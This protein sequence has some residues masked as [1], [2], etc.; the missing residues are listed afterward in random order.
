MEKIA[1]P[2]FQN[3]SLVLLP[4]DVLKEILSYRVKEGDV[5]PWS[6]CKK[7]RQVMEELIGVLWRNLKANNNL[8]KKCQME[9]LSDMMSHLET[10]FGMNPPYLR[11][12]KLLA[13]EIQVSFGIH[14]SS[15]S[16]PILPSHFCLKRL[17]DKSLR[18]VSAVVDPSPRFVF[19]K[20]RKSK[21]RRYLRNPDNIRALQE[22]TNLSIIGNVGMKVVPPDLTLLTQLQRLDL[23]DNNLIYLPDLSPLI[24]LS[25]LSLESNQL[26]SIN[27]L[28]NLSELRILK[29]RKNNLTALPDISNLFQLE[30]LDLSENKL[31]TMP[32]SL[33]KLTCLEDLNLKDNQLSELPQMEGKTLKSM[34][35]GGNK[36]REFPNFPELK[37]LCILNNPLS[38]LTWKKV[39][40]FVRYM[41]LSGCQL[42]TLPEPIFFPLIHTWDLSENQLTT[43]PD[44][45]KLF[46]LT[47]LDL[48]K[49]QFSNLPNLS[50]PSHL[51]VLKISHNCITDLSGLSP[52]SFFLKVLEV[53]F[54]PIQK[55]PD[56]STFE[57][58]HTFSASG[59]QIKFLPYSLPKNIGSLTLS[60]SGLTDFSLV[61]FPNLYMLTLSHNKLSSVP[62]LEALERLWYLDLGHNQLTQIPEIKPLRDLRSL[63]LNDNQLSEIPEFLTVDLW[64]LHL[65]NNNLTSLDS[66]VGE[67]LTPDMILH[68]N[69]WKFPLGHSIVENFIPFL[70]RKLVEFYRFLI[71]SNSSAKSVEDQ[72]KQTFHNLPNK[73]KTRF[74]RVTGVSEDEI[75]THMPSF[76]ISFQRFMI[77]PFFDSRSSQ[78]TE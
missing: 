32:Q 17:F 14:P 72:I 56:L 38:I 9:L 40:P 66:F 1:Q 30:S 62:G 44:T 60:H 6:V 71:S 57:L 35:L 4:N 5:I 49:N 74:Y 2:N 21:A 3:Y 24:H 76:Y 13:K 27:A 33:V 63:K 78:F 26:G 20:I 48:S 68:N 23:S 8:K 11:L 22:N 75:F 25:D 16:V 39:P 61:N 19:R 47:S 28:T 34:D 46:N 53:D 67:M 43:L 70:S 64:T 54:N 50:G 45:S 51:V 77:A 65:Q 42:S 31:I 55:W 15:S 52:L 37:A 73:H 36:F 10:K 29:V 69:P 58:L 41:C 59:C 18:I 12:F 7:F